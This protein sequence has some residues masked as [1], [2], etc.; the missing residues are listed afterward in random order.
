[1][2]RRRLAAGVV[3]Q[4]FSAGQVADQRPGDQLDHG[5]QRRALVSAECQHCAAV[6]HHVGIGRRLTLCIHAP[7]FGDRLA[8]AAVQ[9]DVAPG[10]GAG[11][12]V[13]HERVLSRPRPAKGN[14]IGAEHRQTSPGRRYPGMARVA[15]QRDQALCGQLLDLHP[16]R[17][18]MHAAVDRQCG[19]TIGSGFL[20]QQ[21]Q[22]RLERQLR[23]STPRIHPHDRRCLVDHLRLGRGRHL[24][25]S[26]GIH[27][28]QNPVQTM[29]GAAISLAGD[30]RRRH[31][32]RMGQIKTVV[33]QD[34]FGQL[35][36]F[37]QAQLDHGHL[38]EQTVQG[39]LFKASWLDG[40]GHRG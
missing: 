5:R 36:G 12:K 22:P 39:G 30:H 8:G 28:P 2:V 13:E 6:E 17:G 31:R 35:T 27:T 14:G 16:Q 26:Q 19:N 1:M 33:Q 32:L 7:A 3:S 34:R 23:E 18:K 24:A 37:D 40:F 9:F 21:R 15:R 25:G 29:G 20:R 4:R 38:L 11:G 10:D